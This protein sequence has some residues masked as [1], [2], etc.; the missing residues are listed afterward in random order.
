LKFGCRD[1]FVIILRF[2]S[3]RIISPAF[4]QMPLG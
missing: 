3:G 4:T 2:F 1:H